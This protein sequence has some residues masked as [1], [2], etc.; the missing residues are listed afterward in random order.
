MAPAKNV[1]RLIVDRN[2]TRFFALV[3]PRDGTL[4]CR[5]VS[6]EFSPA[7]T[8]FEHDEVSVYTSANVASRAAA[9]EKLH[10]NV[11]LAAVEVEIRRLR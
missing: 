10:T 2:T 7:E 8:D 11:A 6:V 1:D 9:A 4:F 5:S 3:D